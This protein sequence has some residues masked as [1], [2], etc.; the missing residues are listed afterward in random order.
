MVKV[1]RPGGSESQAAGVGSRREFF[2][3]PRLS[4]RGQTVNHQRAGREGGI[5]DWRTVMRVV[6]CGGAVGRLLLKRLRQANYNPRP[7]RNLH[8]PRNPPVPRVR[9]EFLCVFSVA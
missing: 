7:D 4:A 2:N 1:C 6:G 8:R 9:F 5:E 3:G